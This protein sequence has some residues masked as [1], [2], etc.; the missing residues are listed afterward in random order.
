MCHII[1]YSV[2]TERREVLNNWKQR[3]ET[4]TPGGA[5]VGARTFAIYTTRVLRR[6]ET[7]T[8]SLHCVRARPEVLLHHQSSWTEVMI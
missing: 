6:S 4:N 3:L 7:M 1:C 5:H 8:L 2:V